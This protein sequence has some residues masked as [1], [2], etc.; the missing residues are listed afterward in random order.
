MP[1][2][3][4][5]PPE[6]EEAMLV[7]EISFPPEI[8]DGMSIDLIEEILIYKGVKGVVQNGGEWQP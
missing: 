6:L 4:R 7:T 1:S 8:I 3:F 5:I 2:R